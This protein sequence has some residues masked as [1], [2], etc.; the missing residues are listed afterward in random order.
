MNEEFKSRLGETTVQCLNEWTAR[1]S[2]YP[3]ELWHYTDASGLK[4]ILEEGE[5]WLSDVTLL[6]DRSE[7]SRA[8]DVAEEVLNEIFGENTISPVVREYFQ[9]FLTGIKGHRE[10]RRTYGF[11]NPSFVGCFCKQGDSL[12]LWRSYTEHGKGYSIGLFPDFITQYLTPLRVSE[13]AVVKRTSEMRRDVS[14][15]SRLYKPSWREVIYRSEEQKDLLKR[16][17]DAFVQ[18][19]SDFETDLPTGNV[20]NW[21]KIAF[22]SRLETV[23]NSYLSC[24]KDPAF[25]NEQEWRLIYTLAPDSEVRGDFPEARIHYR[26]FGDYMVPYLKIKIAEIIKPLTQEGSAGIEERDVKDI[27]FETIICGPGLDET[28]ARASLNAFLLREGNLGSL[29]N[30]EASRVPWRVS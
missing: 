30:I 5:L 1:H 27:P 13:I 21:T 12:H 8:V 7:L 24:F 11:I 29:V 2:D 28:L 14:W 18:V 17:F 9:S 22:V 4:G 3:H 26:L 19:A 10:D 20:N 25:E 6:N 15:Q 23:F 16:L